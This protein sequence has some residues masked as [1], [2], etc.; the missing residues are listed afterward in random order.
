MLYLAWRY[1]YIALFLKKLEIR[2]IV[3]RLCLSSKTKYLITEGD[4]C[5]NQTTNLS[6]L[7]LLV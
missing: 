2:E 3:A 4:G 7:K 6:S 5:Q 1:I